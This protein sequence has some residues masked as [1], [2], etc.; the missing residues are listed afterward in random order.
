MKAA[1]V[2]QCPPPGPSAYNWRTTD[3]DEINRRRQRAR[4]EAFRITNLDARHPIFSNFRVQSGSGLSYT[5]EIE[6]RGRLATLLQLRRFP[7]QRA[8]HV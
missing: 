6:T 3:E 8:G 1:I 5:V 2:K 4:D 7:H